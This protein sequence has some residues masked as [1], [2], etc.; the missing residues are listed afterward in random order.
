MS[1]IKYIVSFS[2]GKDSTAMLLRLIEEKKPIDEI[3]FCDTGKEFPDMIKH[4]KKVEDYI[5]RP[6][7]ILKAE[8][9]FDYIFAEWKRADSSEYS[10]VKGYGWPSAMKRWCTT[11]LKTAVFKKYIKE[12]YSDYKTYVGL[13]YDERNRIEKNTDKHNIYPLNDWRMTENDCLHYCYDRGF[14]WN[15]LYKIFNRVSCYLCPL[16]KKSDWLNLEKHYPELLADALR[17]DRLSPYKFSPKE[18]LKQRLERWRNKNQLDLL[19]QS[20]VA[21]D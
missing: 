6:I 10:N 2:G 14:D 3:I 15:G 20:D 18:T 13:A 7:T 4:I 21:E 5:K 12:H 1:K 9:S 8:N 17:L 11:M 16:Q 19:E